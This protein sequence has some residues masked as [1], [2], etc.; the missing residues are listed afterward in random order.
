MHQ[1]KL[2]LPYVRPNHSFSMKKKMHF[3]SMKKKRR[4][5][6]KSS[7]KLSPNSSSNLKVLQLNQ[8]LIETGKQKGTEWQLY[9]DLHFI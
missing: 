2:Y 3:L 7:N 9:N 5:H 1:H 4:F 8:I 6:I